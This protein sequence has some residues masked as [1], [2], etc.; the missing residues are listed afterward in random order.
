MYLCCELDIG[1]V[2]VGGL[3]QTFPDRKGLAR[4]KVY[5]NGMCVVQSLLELLDSIVP[6]SQNWF[7]KWIA[8]QQHS[9]SNTVEQITRVRHVAAVGYGQEQ[10][11][12]LDGCSLV[13][14]VRHRVRIA[15]SVVLRT[16][17]FV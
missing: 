15:S 4:S 5:F 8:C 16:S 10:R 14:L 12:I 1:V 13:L 3:L 7:Y 2:R 9:S 6:H 11:K 17:Y